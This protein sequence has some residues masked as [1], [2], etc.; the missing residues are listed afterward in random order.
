MFVAVTGSQIVLH[1]HEKE[2]CASLMILSF[3]NINAARR[4]DNK[5]QS[6]LTAL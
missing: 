2:E 3:R 6:I 5:T 4:L 1:V